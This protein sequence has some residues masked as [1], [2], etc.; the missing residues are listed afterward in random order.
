MVQKTLCT[1]NRKCMLIKST[2]NSF[3]DWES[4]IF[5][6]YI[7]NTVSFN[8][9][10]VCSMQCTW[11]VSLQHKVKMQCL[12]QRVSTGIWLGTC[13]QFT[14]RKQ[15]TYH[16][17]EHASVALHTEQC[18]PHTCENATFCLESLLFFILSI[19]YPSHKTWMHNLSASMHSWP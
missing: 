3:P 9:K 14:A 17:A 16:I 13:E 18:A 5:V 8:L 6:V 2:T 11:L 4:E 19:L 7:G 1:I 12:E 15:P 10:L